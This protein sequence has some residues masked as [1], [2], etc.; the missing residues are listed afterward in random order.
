MLYPASSFMFPEL[1][2]TWCASVRDQ[3]AVQMIATAQLQHDVQ[4]NWAHA[5]EAGA[6]LLE[7]E[8]ELP[9]HLQ[10]TPPRRSH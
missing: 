5:V 2:Q 8:M 7:E 6:E 10:Q 9:Y 4:S 1:F 3:A